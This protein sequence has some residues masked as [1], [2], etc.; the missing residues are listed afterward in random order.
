MKY[1]NGSAFR[2]AL[3][4]RLRTMS[5]QTGMSLTRL[6]KMVVFDRYLARLLHYQ[7]GR[8]ILKGGLALQLRLGVEAR[9]TKDIDLLLLDIQQNILLALRSAGALDLNDWF[10]FEIGNPQIETDEVGGKRYPVRA[11]L[12]TRDFE[13]FHID[14]G[15]TDA[16]IEAPDQLT[17]PELLTF[18]DIQPTIIPCY[19]LTQ[20]ISEKLHAYTRLH[21]SGESSRVKDFVNMLLIASLAEFQAD[22]LHKAIEVTFLQRGTHP[23]PKLLPEPSGNWATTFKKL[24]KDVGAGFPSLDETFLM[25]QKFLNPI[26]SDS[27]VTHWDSIH[28]QW[29]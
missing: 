15:M 20:Q 18:A 27:P 2:R 28:W 7:P 21:A 8:W 24:S 5:M 29:D 11:I 13:T 26:L 14:I 17:T 3:E 9:T 4:D 6:R 12:D 10:S 16:L 22:R 19:P 25:L 23:F 1:D